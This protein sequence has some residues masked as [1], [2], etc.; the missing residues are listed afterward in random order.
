MLQCG[1][2]LN[3]R[4]MEVVKIGIRNRIIFPRRVVQNQT[5][6]RNRDK[7]VF[8]FPQLSGSLNCLYSAMDS[9]S[10]C[11]LIRVPLILSSERAVVNGWLFTFSPSAI[12]SQNAAKSLEMRQILRS[13]H[14]I[15]CDFR[16]S[17]VV[18]ATLPGNAI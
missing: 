12:I 14:S 5:W 6:L 15:S 9:E 8:L 4:R 7:W 3:E 13:P 10:E 11:Q 1:S 18:I 17:F 2:G 16:F